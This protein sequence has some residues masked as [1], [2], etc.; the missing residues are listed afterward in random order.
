M[1]IL[2]R[3]MIF[4]YDFVKTFIQKF[5]YM[6]DK[7]VVDATTILIN[8]IQLHLDKLGIYVRLLFSDFSVLCFQFHPA[9]FDEG[10]TRLLWC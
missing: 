3:K 10:E 4:Y 9:T 8:H 6:E 1:T 2:T 5:A 7:C